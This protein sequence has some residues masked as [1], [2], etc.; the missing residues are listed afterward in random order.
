MRVIL[1]LQTASFIFKE[2]KSFLC[3]QPWM[4]QFYCFMTFSHFND[5]IIFSFPSS[6]FYDI[7]AYLR[8]KPRLLYAI[9]ELYGSFDELDFGTE[10]L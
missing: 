4:W 5:I 9:I 6:F 10:V 3:H 1:S 8:I 2:T 7:R